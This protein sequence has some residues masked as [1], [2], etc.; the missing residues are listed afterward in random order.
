MFLEGFEPSMNK[1]NIEI[2]NREATPAKRQRWF[3]RRIVHEIQ[4]LRFP[5][6]TG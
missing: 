5:P 1:T 4:A 3:G 6:S 2:E